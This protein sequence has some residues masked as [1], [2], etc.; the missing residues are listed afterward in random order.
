MLRLKDKE[1]TLFEMCFVSNLFFKI[2]K[3][4]HL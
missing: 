3:I 2:S 1:K 4:G